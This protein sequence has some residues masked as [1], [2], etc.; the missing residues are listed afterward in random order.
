MNIDWLAVAHDRDGSYVTVPL[1][2]G[3]QALAFATHV[4]LGVRQ[5]VDGYGKAY[6]LVALTQ[7]HGVYGEPKRAG[8]CK[9]VT[10]RRVNRYSRARMRLMFR[11]LVKD[12]CREHGPAWDLFQE[13]RNTLRGGSCG[14]KL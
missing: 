12:L 9:S 13:V 7:D 10:A 1:P 4:V 3:S 8:I 5:A 6:E 11:D 14:N 2:A